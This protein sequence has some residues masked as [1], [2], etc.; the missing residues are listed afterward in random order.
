MDRLRVCDKSRHQRSNLT[1]DQ[2]TSYDELPYD[3]HPYERTH[4][5]NLATHAQIFGMQPTDPAQCR[6]LELGCA[7]GGNLIP[8]AVS[9]PGSELV[10][11]DLSK[12]QIADGLQT[13]DALNLENIRLQAV[14]ILDFELDG[15]TF[16]YILCHGVY[17][18]VDH[19]V[20]DRI[21]Q[22]CCEALSPQG[23]A[24]IS[25]NTNP[26]WYMRHLVWLLFC[27]HARLFESP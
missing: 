14:S 2:L 19:D 9:L 12:R 11:I 3:S 24:Y 18:W 16:D 20:Q 21:M 27:Y 7:S 15:S 22:I 17:S 25:Y 4:P 6:I 23:V 10:G 26:G 8:M 13:I 1:V 5:D